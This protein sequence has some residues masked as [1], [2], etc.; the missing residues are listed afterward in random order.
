MKALK[1]NIFREI[2]N[3][4]SRFISIMAIIGLSTGFFTG[5]K[6]SCPSMIETGRNYFEEKN[7]MDI[8]LISTVGFDD[9]DI[10]AIKELDTTVDV[11]PGYTADLI[12]TQENV[13]TV[14]RVFSLPEK[15]DTN[16]KLI[17]ENILVE[18]RLPMKSDECVIES[19]YYGVANTH[20]GDTIS[21]NPK[22]EDRDTTDIIDRLEYKI[23]GVVSNPLYITY[24]RGN[25]TVGDGSVSFYMMIPSENFVSE[26]YTNVYLTTTDSGQVDSELTDEYK[27]LIDTQSKNYETLSKERIRHFNE[28]TLADAQNE[29]AD[30]KTEYYD[31]K[32]EAEKEL[33]DGAKKLHDG[34]KEF[35]EKI[36]EAEKKLTDAEK[37]LEDGKKELED[38]QKKFADGIIEAKQKLT[39]AQNQY[40]EGKAE[41][42]R[43]KLQYDTEIAKAQSQLTAAENEY[44]MQYSLFFGST[45]PQAES[46][47]TIIKTGIDLCNDLIAK[48]EEKIQ[49][50]RNAISDSLDEKNLTIA[51][52]EAE[53][54]SLQEKL[55]EYKKKLSDYQK[56]YD[57][58]MNQL[59]DAENQFN[60]SK[61]QLDDAKAQFEE[62][63]AEGALQLNDAQI[64][65]DSAESQLEIGRLEYE[66][67]MTSG[68]M[69]LQAAQTKLSEGEKE[70]EK[71]RAELEQQK[72][73]GMR[74][75]KEAR[76]QLATGKIEAKV[77]LEDAE[78]K[79]NDA[80]ESI[81]A[82]DDAKWY[83]YTREDNPGY[84]GLIED[85]ERVDN[86]A[87]VFPVFFLLVAALVC[88]TTMSRMVEE[89]RTEIGTLK[90][91]GYSNAK[92]ASKYFIYSASAAI[93][94]SLIG[95]VIGIATLPF[96]ILDTYGI[97]YTL[98]PS[99]LVIDWGS[100]F[101]SAGTG[102]LCTCL[103]A[104]ITC[105]NELKIR[106]AT[107]MRPKAPK[108]GKRILLERITFLW[109]HMN[110]TAKVTARNIFRY[111]ARFLMTV[112]GVA[113]CT[114]LII[115]G[116]GLKDSIS[117]I[118]DRQYKEI[119]IFDEIYALKTSGTSK[120][121][122][123]IMSQFHND[124]RFS[125]TLLVSQNWTSVT[126]SNREKI[127]FRYIIGEK[128][129]AFE[130]IFILRDRMTHEK[131]DLDDTGLVINE[132]LA[133]VVDVKVGDTLHFTLN[134]DPYQ[135]VV[136]GIT[137]NY[138]G[139]Y[140]YMSP[141]VYQKITGK[142]P[143]Y[144]I[145][146]TQLAP[147]AKN[148]E[149]DII[150]DWMQNDEI[151]TVSMLK[152]Q[153]DTIV[154]TLS[155][156]DVIVLVLV[157]C[158]GMLAFVVLYNL[159]NINIAERYREI[160][161]I[162]VLGFYNMET[163][164]YIYRE[165]TILTLVGALLGL[166]IGRIFTSFIM[167]KLQMKMVMFP[168][169]VNTISF[170][171]GFALTILFSLLV[172]FFMYFKMKNISMVESLKSIE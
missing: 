15:T 144:N 44:N 19:Y 42:T 132:R 146:Y 121:K 140:M 67:A 142:E 92:I 126:C 22:T 13:D 114:A 134:D 66:T 79:L 131:I 157:F 82:L 112:I 62:K 50:I 104:V 58:G 105:L 28:T 155:S 108:P 38:G 65:L 3:T 16:S 153:L 127:N 2:K 147:E 106:P 133:E 170:F 17:N 6:A 1:K 86:I 64:K 120:E 43:A 154:S 24:L 117:V 99:I 161:T 118:A 30:A 33:G 141:T 47:L 110:F 25:T 4:K 166:P 9:D 52:D 164:N 29:L 151:M 40:S 102:L 123:Y 46:K 88:L 125:E 89:R 80:Q 8:R 163:A 136:S 75:L 93:L 169:Q 48:T 156:L 18:G 5:V 51:V 160:A 100:F 159:T 96:I 76:E 31:K 39:D 97:M 171:I 10:K 70:L 77:Q 81:D 49:T 119:S 113:G 56:Q 55:D 34:E 130:K 23:V 158:A 162:K 101:F 145:V 148:N 165:N 98:P 21:F 116:L 91:L 168:D 14:V 90:A 149:K 72:T 95:G 87:A 63:K 109:K 26:R 78:K 57:D 94:G 61:K 27:D 32:E 138:A 68:M 20:I 35:S 111:K 115:G 124:Q 135:C 54:P 83:I 36:P 129:E 11:M 143:Q 84:S 37:E 41:Y 128:D 137:E 45:K 152:E 60:D 139:N 103:V 167:I 7:L 150:N 172:N 69:E 53:L 59:K 74:R 71:G 73:E 122:E 12:L 85:A 107:L